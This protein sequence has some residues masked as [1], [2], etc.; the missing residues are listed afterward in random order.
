MSDNIL[1]PPTEVKKRKEIVSIVKDIVKEAPEKIVAKNTSGTVKVDLESDGRFSLPQLLHF[2]D[3]TIEDVNSLA[4]SREDEILEN[5][6]SILNTMVVEENIR[7]EDATLDE[8]LEILV[9]IKQQF[10][11][12]A[13]THYWICSCQNREKEEDQII[14]ETMLSLSNINR[15]NIAEIDAEMQESFKKKLEDVSD[16]GFNNFLVMKYGEDIPEGVTKESEVEKVVVKE[17]FYVNVDG[18]KVGFNF[19]RM[20]DML[21]ADLVAKKKLN[22]S[23]ARIK[24]ETYA[25]VP[26]AEKKQIQAEKIEVAK[27]E[28][29]K[30]LLLY[31]KALAIDTVNGKTMSDSEKLE[32]YRVIPREYMLR[33]VD[34]LDELSYG[35][36]EEFDF[37]CPICEQ[38][39]KRLLQQEL[40]PLELLPLESNSKSKA[41]RS[42]SIDI[43]FGI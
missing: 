15:T 17:P 27:A 40:N 3:F 23:I 18:D 41:K 2:K 35:I 11:G 13:H 37:Y 1:V 20:G 25:N 31:G 38:S 22:N 32:Y 21:K 16:D 8:F 39:D 6:I 34:F 30:L 4:L 9:S 43:Y 5:L 33:I 14:N 10:S 29:N 24:K 7:M 26:L 19:V 36:N 12:D 42:E 28:K